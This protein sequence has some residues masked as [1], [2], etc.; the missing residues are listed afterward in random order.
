MVFDDAGRSSTPRPPSG[1]NWGS[2]GSGSDPDLVGWFR[3]HPHRVALGVVGILAACA[4]IGLIRDNNLIFFALLFWAAIVYVVWCTPNFLRRRQV[5]DR[6]DMVI[7]GGNGREESVMKATR[8]YIKALDPPHVALGSTMLAPGV[9]RG[10]TGDT[11]PFIVA[12][13]S[14]NGR[15]KS[16][17]MFVNVRDYGEALQTSWYLAYLPTFW[18]RFRGRLG[19]DL[20]LFDEQDLRAYVTVVHQCFVQAVIDLIAEL[21]KDIEVNRTSKGFLGVS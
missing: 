8:G 20:D 9:W 14:T 19:L 4:F 17:W 3:T 21:G 7:A 12:Q 15:I 11:R 13:N 10:L 1:N 6:W 18:Q 5:I 16:Y 2:G